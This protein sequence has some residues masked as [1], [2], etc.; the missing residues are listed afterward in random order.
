MSTPH[1]DDA[2]MDLA[3]NVEGLSAAMGSM[4]IMTPPE[5]GASDAEG[6]MTMTSRRR[7]VQHAMPC[8]A[9]DHHREARRRAI[10]STDVTDAS[11]AEG[12]AEAS[13]VR[14][15]EAAAAAVVPSTAMACAHAQARQ[16]PVVAHMAAPVQGGHPASVYQPHYQIGEGVFASVWKG[17]DTRT[18]QTVAI[19]HVHRWRERRGP[20]PAE[21][22]EAQIL[23]RLQSPWVVA[24]LD[25]EIVPGVYETLIL[26]YMPGGDLLDALNSGDVSTPMCKS[27]LIQAATAVAYVHESGFVHADVKLENL[28]IH[29]DRLK[30][31]DFGLSGRIGQIRAG[32]P[33]G[34]TS[35]MA[36][37]L[38]T[39]AAARRHQ[40]TCEL[41]VWSLG[42]ALFR[43]VLGID[44]PWQEASWNDHEFVD[45]V[46]E[47]VTEQEPWAFLHPD[48]LD[49]LLA[50][51]A[52]GIPRPSAARVAELLESTPAWTLDPDE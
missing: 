46:N 25:S 15:G 28:L 32:Q 52:V 51:L 16:A 37:E 29:G 49:C 10:I 44:M 19:K 22:T 31:C 20:G 5:S 47:D 45:F 38:L 2:H 50:M 48:F 21:A 4:N 11:E 41:D 40:L 42:I 24:L 14:Q 12:E 27:Y 8:T 6:D 3:H 17:V 34:T 43:A 35:Y 13:P 30:L 18:Q 39:E 1:F 36:P 23:T 7:W 33:H 26:E 9:F